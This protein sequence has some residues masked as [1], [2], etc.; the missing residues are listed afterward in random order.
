MNPTAMKE[1]AKIGFPMNRLV[2]VWWSG[3][4]DDARPA[5]AEAKGYSSLDLN[6]VGSDFPVIKDIV[7]YVVDKGKSQVASKD[8]V[9]EN[10]Y[11][12]AVLNSV[13]VAEAIRNGSAADRQEAGQRRG[14]APRLRKSQHHAGAFEGAGP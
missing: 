2:G 7:K 14:R 4:D 10:F 5:G 1:A 13:L 3:N 11:D 12:R 8:K 9:G 6:A